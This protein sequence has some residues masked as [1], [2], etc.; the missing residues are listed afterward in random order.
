MDE[1]SKAKKNQ[2]RDYFSDVSLPDFGVDTR[3]FPA[4]GKRLVDLSV[5]SPGHKVLDVA[6]GRGASLFPAAE[7]AGETGEVIGIDLAE[8]MVLATEKEIG[9][10]KILNASIRLMDAE[11]LQFDS[12]HFDRVLCGFAL[13]FMPRLE[14][15]L[16]E[17][18]RVLR[19]GG[20]SVVSTF[21]KEDEQLEWYEELLVKYGISRE[22]PAT[23]SLD[24][25]D[26][27]QS[28]FSDAGFSGIRIVQ[29][30]F[31][32]EYE[33]EEDWWSR[34]W[35]TA[36]RIALETLNRER[37]K[38]LRD[39]AFAEVQAFE[40]DGKIHIPY[41]VLFTLAAKEEDG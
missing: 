21:G 17:F 22:I 6:A 36:D 26:D 38:A 11:Q 32:S 24:D 3:F 27:L 9:Q 23:Q 5:I 18:Y 41:H 13:F 40:R 12:G 10:R 30:R 37:Q 20:K 33:D 14:K 2:V 16:A 15:A 29:E 19:R 28:A 25:P 7:R 1:R 34:L 8:G 35:S 39:E 31:D 4:M